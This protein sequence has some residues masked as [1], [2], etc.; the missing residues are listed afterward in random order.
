MIDLIFSL[1]H[2]L[3]HA[4]FTAS[5][6]ASSESSQIMEFSELYQTSLPPEDLVETT[7]V[8][9]MRYSE[10]ALQ[11]PSSGDKTNPQLDL[12]HRME[13][14]SLLKNSCGLFKHLGN[15]TIFSV[16]VLYQVCLR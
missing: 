5:L 14:S 4:S 11:A 2:S 6:T 8:P 10:E 7:G 1:S 16:Q 15:S 12:P 3:E 9:L 13:I